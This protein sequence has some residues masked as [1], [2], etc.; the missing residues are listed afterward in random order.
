MLKRNLLV[1][2]LLAGVAFAA[3]VL[4]TETRFDAPVTVQTGTGINNLVALLQALGNSVGLTV[5][6]DGVPADKTISYNIANKP[7][8]EVW[9]LLIKLNDLDYEIIG[10]DI[11]VVGTKAVVDKFRPAPVVEPPVV[12]APAPDPVVRQFYTIK[13]DPAAVLAFLQAEAKNV[14]VT[15]FGNSNLIAISGTASQQQEVA[16]LLQVVD[17]PPATTDTPTTTQPVAEPT[18][19][20]FYA[21]N[22][23]ADEIAAF[24]KAEVPGAV[25]NRV[26]QTRTLSIT[27]TAKQ[28]D[29]IAALLTTVDPTPAAQV[30]PVPP[31][32][33][34]TVRTFYTANMAPEDVIAFL[35]AEVPTA[36]VNR[37]GQTRTLSINA[38]A[39][40]Q[41]E[42]ANLLATVDP[43]PAPP[44]VVEPTN[45]TPPEP[46]VRRFYTTNLDP[47]EVIT[48][49]KSE[50]P[51]AVINR[52]GSTRT[53]SITATAKQQEEITGLLSSVDIAPEQPAPV[54]RIQQIF[55]LSNAKA[56]DLRAVLTQTFAT[57][58]NSGTSSTGTGA[59]G[60]NTS[61]GTSITLVTN[62]N[63]STSTTPQDVSTQAPEII[64]D[65]RTNSLI[66]RGTQ[67]QLNQISEA[68]AAL[69]KRV[70]QVNV[71]VRIQEITRSAANS[72]GLNWNAPFGNFS[73]LTFGSGGV[74]SVFNAASSLVGFNLG[75]TLDAME[76]Q[77][78][79]KRVDDGS[80]T[81]QSGQAEPAAMKSGGTLI[82]SIV[83]DGT[84]KIERTLD[85]GVN[86]NISNL[87][88]SND[89]TITMKVN[90]SVKG[91][92]SQPT[93]PTL[94]NLTNNEAATVLSF[95]SGSTV[96]LGGLLSTSRNETT[97]G[98]PILSSIP[99]IGGLF[100][101]TTVEDKETQLM[102]VITANTIE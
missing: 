100:K 10:N 21:T 82:V 90:A 16:N 52:V 22:L 32:P 48:F 35:K 102:L 98:V 71:Q 45:Q 41:K 1:L 53:L 61:G 93:D 8:R 39:A 78:L 77:G 92:A 91:F 62:P 46:T 38:T 86:V 85:Y 28:Q 11:V 26:G 44:A 33:E 14:T 81:L 36:V 69:D 68:I 9:D 20:R 55:R 87:Q 75:A 63:P 25:I 5:V 70:P 64:A 56:D 67:T 94:L 89:G 58:S 73:T 72:L 34:P 12:T 43:A 59:S 49:L 3:P 30:Q 31:A 83:G 47:V 6:T 17:V 13:S 19:R 4:P 97:Q 88:V 96:L 74:K 95:K 42:I 51:G 23:P 18:V 60:D 24:L 40:Q 29:E 79:L 65:V 15:R 37:V 2:S 84:Q 57:G 99:L 76:K 80:L 54:V 101:S 7:F 50:V 27:A 66:V